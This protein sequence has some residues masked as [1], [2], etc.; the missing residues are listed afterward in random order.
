MC[1]LSVVARNVNPLLK[2]SSRNNVEVKLNK[3]ILVKIVERKVK[4]KSH[5]YFSNEFKFN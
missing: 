4:V 5:C 1:N 2:Y 3:K